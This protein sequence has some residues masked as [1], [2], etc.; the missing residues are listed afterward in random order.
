MA[1]S[2]GFGAIAKDLKRLVSYNQTMATV[3]KQK[4][5]ASS[6]SRGQKVGF[7]ISSVLSSN[8]TTL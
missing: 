5:N 1:V 6:H 4:E 3:T 8:S 7:E 2:E